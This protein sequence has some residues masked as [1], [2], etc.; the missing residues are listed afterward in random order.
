MSGLEGLRLNLTH[1]TPQDILGT[2]FKTSLNSGNLVRSF[3]VANQPQNQPDY[4]LVWTGGY[5][6]YSVVN[7]EVFL[8]FE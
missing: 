7:W 4:T 1:P 2:N 6:K 3:G 5:I 8:A